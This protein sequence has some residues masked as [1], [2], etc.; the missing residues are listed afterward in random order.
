[1]SYRNIAS[2]ATPTDERPR[3]GKTANSFLKAK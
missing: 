3:K 2:A 1:M